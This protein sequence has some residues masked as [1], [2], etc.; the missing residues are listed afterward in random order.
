MTCQYVPTSHDEMV[1]IARE[2]LVLLTRAPQARVASLWES[3]DAGADASRLLDVLTE[4][5]ISSTPEFVLVSGL[6]SSVSV[7][8]ARG[9]LGA[10]VVNESG[11][12]RIDGAGVS[13]WVET[14]VA[15]VR[16]LVL[17]SPE[18]DVGRGVE[19]LP[20]TRGVVRAAGVRWGTATEVAQEPAPVVPTATAEPVA[21]P[22]PSPAP[23]SP[24]PSAPMPSAPAPSAPAPSAAAPSAAAPS[25]APPAPPSEATLGAAA[26]TIMPPPEPDDAPATPAPAAYDAAPGGE[27]DHLFGATMMRNVEDA[28]VREDESGDEEETPISD[29]TVVVDDIAALRAQR[30]AERKKSPAAAPVGPRFRLEL[31]SGESAPLD[32]AIILGRAPSASRVSGTTVPRLVTLTTPNQD[33][34]RSHVQVAVEGDTVVVTDLH[35]MNGTLITVPG[36]NPV[37]LREGEPTTVITD[38]VIDLGDGARLVVREA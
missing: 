1:V 25:P 30:R 19:A 27:Y 11:E 14:Q 21:P 24:A 3:V 9:S 33:I 7:V 22:E 34:S 36:R 35:S 17:D 8:M 29:R 5:G 23:S 6:G 18:A 10:T 16:H 4:G 37:R 38:T 15:E 20:L 26:A 28:A 32:Q 31:P 13:S 2:D 12:R